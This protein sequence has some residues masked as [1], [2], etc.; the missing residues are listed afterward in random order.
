MRLLRELL[1]LSAAACI[2]LALGGYIAADFPQLY[3]ASN[4]VTIAR[5]NLVLSTGIVSLVMA[6]RIATANIARV[7]G[8][9]FRLHDSAGLLF[10]ANSE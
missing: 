7:V 9:L 5:C 2:G 4:F 6:Y 3:R 1:T 8:W 10:L